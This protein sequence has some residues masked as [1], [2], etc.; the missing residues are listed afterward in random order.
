MNGGHETSWPED[1]LDLR[2]FKEAGWR[3]G[4]PQ[5]VEKCEVAE[6]WFA[7]NDP[8]GG[9]FEKSFA[10][11]LRLSAG[12]LLSIGRLLNSEIVDPLS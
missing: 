11:S 9:A 1:L 5:G 6:T 3:Q 2:Q 10:V 12:G 8:G 4:P 7:E